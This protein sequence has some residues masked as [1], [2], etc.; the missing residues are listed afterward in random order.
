M[1]K[2]IIVRNNIKISGNGVQPMVFAHGF[3]CDQQMWRYITPSF[4]RE[5]Q[6]ILFD[7]VGSGKSDQS[8]YDFEKYNSLNGYAEDLIEICDELDLQNVIFVGHSVSSI[9]GA[10]AS[11]KRPDLFEKLIMIGP[12]PCYI[13]KEGY[14]GGFSSEDIDELVETLESNY[15]GWSSHITPVIVGNP[16]MPEYSEELRNSF[17]NMNPEIAKHFAKVTFLG[18]NREDLSQVLTPSLIIQ[19]HPDIIAPVKVG[20]YVHKKMPESKYFLLSASG[21]CPHLTAPDQVISSIQNFLTTG[22]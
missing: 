10:L 16:E 19:C 11:I 5:Y 1:N 18:D 22:H 21:H 9:I 4:E 8:A 20:E 15:L 2:E 3:G 12:S 13:N 6:I 14:F 17:C 7:H